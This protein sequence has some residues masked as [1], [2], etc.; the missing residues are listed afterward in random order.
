MASV[1]R[2]VVNEPIIDLWH[3]PGGMIYNA[4]RTWTYET[5][6]IA[7]RNVHSR[8]GDLARSI[9]VN[10]KSHKRSSSGVVEARAPYAS[11]V[12]NG[13][14]VGGGFI[15]P[16]NHRLLYLHHGGIV[17]QDKAFMRA[18]YV[19]GQ[20]ANPFL[21][22]ALHVMITTN[23]QIDSFMFNMFRKGL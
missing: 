12:H 22:N 18:R 14:M 20:R 15:F 5:E 21:A 1:S 9:R 2:V 16:E 23:P 4:L 19:R 7:K 6:G 3:Q 11:Y 17:K 10:F 8:S 13:T